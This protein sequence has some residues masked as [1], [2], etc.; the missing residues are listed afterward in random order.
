MP[1]IARPERTVIVADD[2]R[3]EIHPN[4]N[5]RITPHDGFP[6]AYLGVYDLAEL[7][8]IACGDDATLLEVIA[9]VMKHGHRFRSDFTPERFDYPEGE[10]F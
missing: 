6:A 4:G 5:L 9:S 3:I 2:A 1:I 10:P 8:R 7:L